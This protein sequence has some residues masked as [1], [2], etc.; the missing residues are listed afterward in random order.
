MIIDD[1]I[2]TNINHFPRIA[3]LMLEN[4]K[5]TW[6]S[7]VTFQDKLINIMWASVLIC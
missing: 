1:S 2:N 7:V 6:A 3:P 5:T 4:V